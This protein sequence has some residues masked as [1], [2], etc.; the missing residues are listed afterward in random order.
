M[1]VNHRPHWQCQQTGLDDELLK[2]QEF[3]STGFLRQSS[4]ENSA[5]AT[6]VPLQS[7]GFRTKKGPKEGLKHD[8]YFNQSASNRN[9]CRCS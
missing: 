8:G 4:A 6:E 5:D 9:G 7:Q 2:R 3:R 1:K